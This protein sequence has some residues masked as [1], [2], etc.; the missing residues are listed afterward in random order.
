MAKTKNGWSGTVSFKFG[1][2]R[3]KMPDGSFSLA[4][5]FEDAEP[6]EIIVNIEG[7]SYYDRGVSFGLPEK[8][9]PP[10]GDSQILSCIGPD[11]KDWEDKL[12]ENEK[13]KI[14]AE[15]EERCSEAAYDD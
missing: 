11:N 7:S 10:E 13:F 2:E 15:I 12:T 14:I 3:F 4:P 6:T 9:Y 8:C 1:I 5:P